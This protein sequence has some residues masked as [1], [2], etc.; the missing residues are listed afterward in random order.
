LVSFIAVF[1]QDGKLE[2]H[3]EVSVFTR[4]LQA[5]LYVGHQQ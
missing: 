5:W 4:A 3:H 1:R 2:Q